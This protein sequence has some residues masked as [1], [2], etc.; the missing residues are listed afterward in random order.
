MY[1]LLLETYI[2]DSKEK[3]KLFQAIENIPCVA[4]KA[5]WAL[6]WIKRCLLHSYSTFSILIL[7][8][9]LNKDAI[10]VNA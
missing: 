2:K 7:S 10:A 1:S 5:K 3:H 6:D 4:K 8:S 9:H